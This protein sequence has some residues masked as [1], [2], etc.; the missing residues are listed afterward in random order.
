MQPAAA[1][2]K[3]ARCRYRSADLLYHCSECRKLLVFDLNL[4]VEELRELAGSLPRAASFRHKAKPQKAVSR[5]A[6]TKKL[7]EV[8]QMP[9]SE[10]SRFAWKHPKNCEYCSQ[11]TTWRRDENGRPC[12]SE[13]WDR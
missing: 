13:C 2:R 9:V 12:C 3:C 10:R 6:P 5:V 8:I 11:R 4:P 1:K 7:A